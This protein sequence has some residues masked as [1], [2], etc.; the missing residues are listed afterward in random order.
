MKSIVK[1]NIFNW[2]HI[3]S[4]LIQEQNEL[5][6]YYATYDKKCWA[7][8]KAFK[9]YKKWKVTGDTSSMIF[10]SDSITSV[11]ATSGMTLV[12]IS[13][14]ALLILGYMKHKDIEMKIQICSYAYQSY[15]HLL[16]TI[17]EMIRNGQFEREHLTISMNIIDNF[18]A[19][20]APIIDKILNKFDRIYNKI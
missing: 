14:R 20:N 1:R 16:N 8:K 11:I 18:V 12:A 10:A 2:N 19:N 13:T 5:E 6:S 3:S 9:H 15:Q 4:T 17:K 7:Y